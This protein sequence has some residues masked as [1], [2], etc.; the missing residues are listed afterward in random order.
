MDERHD[1][2]REPETRRL[3]D[4]DVWGA[5]SPEAFASAA[6]LITTGLGIVVVVI[7]LF[8]AM[9]VFFG[10]YAVLNSPQQF[11]PVY[12]Q[13]VELIGG[14]A[15]SVPIDGKPFPLANL[16]AVLVLGLGALVLAWIA[17]A[18]MLTGAKIV[19]WTTSD[20]E[21]IKKILKHAFGSS[22]KP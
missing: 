8:C 4:A 14:E 17:L 15:L 21:A 7:G 3:D 2:R 1:L 20:R 18:I 16:A 9:K 5:F 19:S 6:R 13:W 11:Q 22:G 10:I 12:Q